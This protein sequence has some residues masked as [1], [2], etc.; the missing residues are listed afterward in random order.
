MC[1]LCSQISMSVQQENTTA[2]MR[3]CAT[4]PLAHI[5]ALVGKDM[6]ET[7]E[8]AQVRHR[9][10]CLSIPSF[11]TVTVELIPSSLAGKGMSKTRCMHVQIRYPTRSVP[12]KSKH[13]RY[14]QVTVDPAVYLYLT[15]RVQGYIYIY[16]YI[17]I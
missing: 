8:I 17:Y 7:V 6:L 14:F 3:P 5:T 15:S 10:E 11:K 13:L 12:F 4:T 9:S 16:I 1:W 2:A